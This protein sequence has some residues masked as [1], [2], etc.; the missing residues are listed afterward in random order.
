MMYRFVLPA[1]LFFLS[2]YSVANESSF[3]D[4]YHR[5]SRDPNWRL[6][7]SATFLSPSSGFGIHL[8]TP[9]FFSFGVGK[10]VPT[11]R[12]R[13][14]HMSGYVDTMTYT[15]PNIRENT[16]THQLQNATHKMGKF[17]IMSRHYISENLSSFVKIGFSYLWMD[18][19]VAESKHFHQGTHFAIGSEIWR[20]DQI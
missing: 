10:T 6:G 8:D 14:S 16:E 15:T 20:Y 5:M 1:F 12:S 2:S 3:F 18:E 19:H 9:S 7:V 4:Q 13:T 11:G 17:G